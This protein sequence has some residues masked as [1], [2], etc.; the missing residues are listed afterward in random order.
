LVTEVPTVSLDFDTPR[1]RPLHRV[2]ASEAQRYYRAGQF[3]PGSMGPKVEAA[4][5]FLERGGR[6]SAITTAELLAATLDE[7]GEPPGT[8]IEHALDGQ[9]AG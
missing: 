9:R 7:T 4:L 2:S 8:R 5:H 3:P 1:Q 6:V